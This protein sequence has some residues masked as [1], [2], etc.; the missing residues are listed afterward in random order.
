MSDEIDQDR[1]YEQLADEFDLE[2]FAPGEDS[3]NLGDVCEYLQSVGIPLDEIED[4]ETDMFLDGIN[5]YLK[6]RGMVLREDHTQVFLD[7]Y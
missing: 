7:K 5:E 1:N 4:N 6:L 2:Q 3:I